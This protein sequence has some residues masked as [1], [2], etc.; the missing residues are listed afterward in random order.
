MKTISILTPV[1]K[2]PDNIRRMIKSIKDTMSYETNIQLIYRADETD[3]L[4]NNPDFMAECFLNIDERLYIHFLIGPE[5]F[6]DL[7]CLWNECL[8]G[9]TGDIMQIGG[10]DLVY[11]TKN[12]DKKIAD[13]AGTF[14]DEVYLIWGADAIHNQ[15]L[16]T[17]G[18]VSRKWIETV[19]WF[20]PPCGL[21]YANDNFIH[22][23]AARIGRH[24]FLGDVMIKHLWEGQNDADPNYHRMLTHFQRSNDFFY[25]EEG[26]KI[27]EEA[28]AKLRQI[29]N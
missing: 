8:E 2:R 21:T 15:T 26:R 5:T 23:I 4:I 10:D 27:I 19:G 18:F 3:E 6:P 29:M 13:K 24:C 17:H 16:A 1:R 11:E 25:S 14:Q 28:A 7:G 20:T 9:C 12:W 22:E